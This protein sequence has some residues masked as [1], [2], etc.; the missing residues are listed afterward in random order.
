[1]TVITDPV[2]AAFDAF[3]DAAEAQIVQL[4][5]EIGALRS[6]LAAVRETAGQTRAA[7]PMR[8]EVGPA[9]ERGEPGEVGPQGPPGPQ[10]ERGADG[11]SSEAEITRIAQEKV[12]AALA[13]HMRSWYRGVFQQGEQYEAG[14]GATWDGCMWIAT[15]ATNAAPGRDDSWTLVIKK[16][17]DGRDRMRT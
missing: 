1:M 10:G 2:L 12:G 11:I 14:Q 3:A 17:R 5:S 4:R 8:G 6:E 13:T 9:G 7:E 16:G 15:R